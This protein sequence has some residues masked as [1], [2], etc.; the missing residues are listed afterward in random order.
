MKYLFN[1]LFIDI[2]GFKQINDTYGHNE[3]DHV[4]ELVA[5]VL[6]EICHE[7]GDLCARYG[8]DEFAVV[9]TVEENENIASLCR[10]ICK[11]VEEKNEKSGVAYYFQLSIGCAEYVP[12]ESIQDLI[13]RADSNMYANKDKNRKSGAFNKCG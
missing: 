2:D 1:F 12:G 10:G 7:T 8:G 4:L 11:K 5:L 13:L 9:K 3:G 6:R